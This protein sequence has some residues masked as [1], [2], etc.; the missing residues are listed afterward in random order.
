MYELCEDAAADG[1]RYLEVRFS[2]ILHVEQGLALSTVM[3]AVCEAKTMAELRLPIV[4]RIICCGMRQMSSAVSTQVVA[5]ALPCGASSRCATPPPPPPP[6][7]RPA[8]QLAHVAARYR[9][10]GVVAFD[11]AGPGRCAMRADGARCDRRRRRRRRWQRRRRPAHLSSMCWSK[12]SRASS[13]RCRAPHGHRAFTAPRCSR[14]RRTWSADNDSYRSA[15]CRNSTDR[16][17]C[18]SVDSIARRDRPVG[19]RVVA[20]R[21]ADAHPRWASGCAPCA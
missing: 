15:A 6:P 5:R 10:R 7:P 8:P 19:Q 21:R 17:A 3:E 1:V 13:S 11:L 18:Q 20:Q 9:D 14:H 2:P 16:S 12:I 4:V